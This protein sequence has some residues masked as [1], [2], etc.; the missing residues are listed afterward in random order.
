MIS[1]WIFAGFA[2]LFTGISQTLLK[3]G[4]NKSVSENNFLAAYLNR[5]VI[6]GYFLFLM[7]T[8]FVVYAL[9]EIPLK[10][11]YSLTALNFLVVLLFSY[12]VLKENISKMQIVSVLIIISGVVIFNL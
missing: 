9:R 6:T 2:I 11:F 4:A 3:M 10:V 1:A 12:F 5:H 7:V 8:I